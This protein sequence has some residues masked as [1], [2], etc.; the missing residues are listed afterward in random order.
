[1]KATNGNITKK[2]KTSWGACGRA[3][4]FFL[5]IFVLFAKYVFPQLGCALGVLTCCWKG[6][7]VDI[8]TP[9]PEPGSSPPARPQR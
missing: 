6:L 2:S 8:A 9:C 1:M 7:D 5:A 3:G 4:V